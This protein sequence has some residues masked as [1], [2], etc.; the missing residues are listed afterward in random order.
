MILRGES[1]K[2]CFQIQGELRYGNKSK[3][4]KGIKMEKLYFSGLLDSQRAADDYFK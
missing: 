1:F 4:A 2:G 3:E